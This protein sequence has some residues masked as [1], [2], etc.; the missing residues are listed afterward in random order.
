MT[1][2]SNTPS[3]INAALLSIKSRADNS[4]KKPDLTMSVSNPM[5]EQEIRFFLGEVVPQG[6]GYDLNSYILLGDVIVIFG[7][8]YLD[9]SLP[10]TGGG[11]HTVSHPNG[12]KYWQM[13]KTV[14]I[15]SPYDIDDDGALKYSTLSQ[16]WFQPYDANG[17]PLKV[18]DNP[19][20][21]NLMD[22]GNSIITVGNEPIMLLGGKRMT[23]SCPLIMAQTYSKWLAN[24]YM[25]Y[26]V[27]SK[28]VQ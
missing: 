28:I 7:K 1:I 20:T 12:K 2:S 26:T 27:I 13:Q 8:V 10:E 5:Q 3:Q 15:P 24:C 11:S 18:A 21:P 19:P 4:M 14:D 16:S 9:L 22:Y 17:N 25:D 23:L 6:P